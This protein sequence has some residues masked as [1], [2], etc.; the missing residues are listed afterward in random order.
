MSLEKVYSFKTIEGFEYRIGFSPF[1]SLIIPENINK[2][3][4]DVVIATQDNKVINNAGTLFMITKII[5]EYL[6]SNDVLLYCYCD[7]I[8]INRG[9]KHQ[10]LTPQEYRN[11]LFQKMFEREADTKFINKLIVLTDIN[12]VDHYVQI[13]STTSNISLLQIAE[14][15]LIKLNKP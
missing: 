12:E 3:V 1:N 7:A 14:N 2:P 11:L 6:S 10:K 5:K 15:E 13:I 8:E 4:I 9:L